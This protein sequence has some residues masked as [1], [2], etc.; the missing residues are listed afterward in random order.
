LN[1][2]NRLIITKNNSFLTAD[3]VLEPHFTFAI[4]SI[5]PC[6]IVP[7]PL[8][9]KHD[10]FSCSEFIYN[11]AFF[12]LSSLASRSSRSKSSRN[13]EK[14]LLMQLNDK[15][16]LLRRNCYL[17]LHHIMRVIAI[18]LIVNKL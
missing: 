13:S 1:I 3:S 11:K 10:V 16:D 4:V 12:A 2:G 14:H 5:R 15:V 8:R 17:G 6:P 9:A 7:A 18:N